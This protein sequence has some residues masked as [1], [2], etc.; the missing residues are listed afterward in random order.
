MGLENLIN[1]CV[2]RQ[3]LDKFG[4]SLCTVDGQRYSLGD[5]GER[6]TLQ[7]VCKALIYAIALNELGR[8]TVHK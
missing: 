5:Y 4:M 2:C 1:I 7:S 3:G 8:D 6:F